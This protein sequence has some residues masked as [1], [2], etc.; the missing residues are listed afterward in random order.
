MNA[1]DPIGKHSPGGWSTYGGATHL[2]RIRGDTTGSNIGT[3]PERG[4]Q[5]AQSTAERLYDGTDQLRQ[6]IVRRTG[7][8]TGK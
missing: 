6:A 7:Q 3:A 8:H 5:M 1:R 4:H 2:R